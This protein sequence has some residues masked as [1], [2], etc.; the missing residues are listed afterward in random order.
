[1]AKSTKKNRSPSLSRREPK[2]K[3]QMKPKKPLKPKK[4]RKPEK[5]ALSAG[6]AD[7][8]VH[9]RRWRSDPPPLCWTGCGRS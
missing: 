3:K 6:C 1:M 8:R 2:P 7:V 4:L 9:R 5:R